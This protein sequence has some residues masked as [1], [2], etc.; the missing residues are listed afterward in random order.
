MTA[1]ASLT[2]TPLRNDTPANPRWAACVR[3]LGREPTQNEFGQWC[4]RR[5]DD[6]LAGVGLDGLRGSARTAACKAH[7]R[8][9]EA[10]L[11]A[12]R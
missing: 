6:Y 12:R 5:W 11:G 4:M 3:E 7:G 2:S 1:F 9:F 10:W 8:A